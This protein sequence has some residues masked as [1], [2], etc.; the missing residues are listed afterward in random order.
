MFRD[1]EKAL[2][3]LQKQLLDEEEEVTPEEDLPEDDLPQAVYDDC[4]AYNAD[5][6]D[7]DLDSYCREVF[8]DPQRKTGCSLWFVLVAA[9]VL[10][11]LAYFLAKRGGL[12]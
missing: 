8:E 10:L 4:P 1:R 3:D 2:S 5:T 9:A 7:T 12:L 11:A 6:T